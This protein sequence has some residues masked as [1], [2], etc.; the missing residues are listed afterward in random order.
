MQSI[1]HLNVIS[2][3]SSPQD[4]LFRALMEEMSAEYYD[5]LRN[6]YMH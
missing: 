1:Y 6:N 5:M 2:Q 3:S 4:H